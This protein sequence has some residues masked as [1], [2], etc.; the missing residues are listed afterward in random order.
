MDRS[1]YTALN[2]M[3][4]LRTNQS[5]TSQNLA[6]SSSTGFQKDLSTNFAKTTPDVSSITPNMK[7]TM[8][9]AMSVLYR[10][11][12]IKKGD[13]YL[14]ENYKGSKYSEQMKQSPLSVCIGAMVF[15]Y[16]LN[17][18][19]LSHTLNYLRTELGNNL[20][21]EKLATLEKNGDGISQ[22]LHSLEEILKDLRIS[23][24]SKRLNV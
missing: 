9:K 6:N 11:V 18:E 19:L 17:N 7:Q 15:F 2:S 20:T 4:I 12:T 24:N 8:N 14:I 10:P 13:R 22:S 16:N 3:Q 21:S 5:V 1:I 23:P